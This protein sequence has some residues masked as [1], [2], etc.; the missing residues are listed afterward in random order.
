[1]SAADRIRALRL[2]LHRKL[3]RLYDDLCDPTFTGTM[4][5]ELSAKDGIPGQPRVRVEHYGI[6]EII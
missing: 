5:I 1:M 3:D 4:V 2:W 6:T